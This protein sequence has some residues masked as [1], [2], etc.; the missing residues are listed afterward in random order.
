MRRKVY[1]RPVAR[2]RSHGLL[3]AFLTLVAAALG[4]CSFVAVRPSAAHPVGTADCSDDYVWP[5]VDTLAAVA[6]GVAATYVATRSEEKQ[7]RSALPREDAVISYVVVGTFF[8]GSAAAGYSRVSDCREVR[9]AAQTR[10]S[11]A[12][13]SR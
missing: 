5:F 7:A 13:H 3:P 12:T 11:V 9:A 8:G 6:S 1:H 2:V 4:G 10:V